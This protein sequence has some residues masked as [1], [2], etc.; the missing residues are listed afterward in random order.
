MDAV[1]RRNVDMLTGL[2]NRRAYDQRLAVEVAKSRRYYGRPL[3]LC[4]LDLDGFKRV[5][6]VLGRPTGD[7]VLKEVAGILREGRVADEPFRIGG[8]EFAIL[9]PDT[10]RQGAERAATRIA[11]R[12]ASAELGGGVTVSSGVAEALEDTGADLH[13]EADRALHESKRERAVRGVS[14]FAM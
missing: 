11:E 6:D 13:A 3:A 1:A 8:D 10:D 9:M 2:A 5:N 12:I 7:R 14:A 4:L